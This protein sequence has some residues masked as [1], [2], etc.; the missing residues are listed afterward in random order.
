VTTPGAHCGK[1]AD[2]RRMRWAS[3]AATLV[4][5]LASLGSSST[6]VAAS[7]PSIE[8]ESVSN[9]TP[10]DA[11]LEA[12]INPN[13]AATSYFFEIAKSPACLPVRAPYAPCVL[14]EVGNLPTDV[15]PA[16]DQGQSVSLDLASAGM[17]LEPGAHY[18]FRVVA[19]NSGGE[20]EG[21]GRTFTATLKPSIESES[22]S[23]VTRTD[24]TLEAQLNAQSEERGA[25]YQFQVAKNPGEFAPEFTC[26]TKG[27]PAGSSLCLG[28]ASQEGALPIGSIP[29]GTANRSVSLDLE[30]V[31]VSLE[32]DTT[33]YYRIIAARVV[34]TEDTT[35]WEEPITFGEAKT[36]TTTS[37]PAPNF[38]PTIISESVSRIT[39]TDAMVEAKVNPNGQSDWAQFQLVREP[40]EYASEILCPELLWPGFSACTGAVSSTALPIEFV[41]GNA[42]Y[43]DS[44]EVVSL[45]LASAGVALKPGTTYHYRVLAAPSVQTEDMIQWRE[46]TAFGSDQ[47]FATASES[48]PSGNGAGG[49]SGQLAPAWSAGPIRHPRRH[50]HRR[51]H[52]QHRYTH[53]S[54]HIG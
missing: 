16:S 1:N 39:T 42:L 53:R 44:L 35:L 41:P 46:S 3:S 6:A 22:V 33:Y 38:T 30:T 5:L 25:Y 15:L 10:A 2:L 47:T 54:G 27:F 32:P 11:T 45:D 21:E 26:P 8:S 4:A 40:S 7:P 48:L 52:R 13:G 19:T 29:T 17:N 36:F 49:A 9:V 20:A 50:R 28:I 31:G 23:G 12:R 24:V 34:P 14:I 18:S 37:S 43:P 51:R